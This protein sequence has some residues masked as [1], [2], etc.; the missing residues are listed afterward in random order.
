M[1][2]GATDWLFAAAALAAVLALV[3]GL[4]RGARA[5]GL[6]LAP[7]AG[8]RLQTAELLAL[9]PRRRLV[10]VRCDGREVLLLIGGSHDVVVGW[11]P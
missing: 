3:W 5:A 1:T 6:G 10:I 8:K 2:P 7:R 4:A 11:L 9:D